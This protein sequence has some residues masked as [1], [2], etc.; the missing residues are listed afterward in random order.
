[1]TLDE[2]HPLEYRRR[3]RAEQQVERD[4]SAATNAVTARLAALDAALAAAAGRLPEKRLAPARELTCRATERLRLS[5]SHTVVALAGATGSGKSSLFNALAG[6]P[7]SAVG[8]RRP[9]TG[10]AHAVIWGAQGAGPLLDWLQIPRR[11]YLSFLG[12]PD[13]GDHRLD[14]LVLLDMPD[15]DS[16]TVPHRLE[17]D[18]L[19]GLV[20]VLVW[21]LDPQKYAD[22]AVHDR[23]LRPLAEHAGVVVVVL[24]QADLLP[25]HQVDLALD[26]VRRLLAADGLGTVPVLATS[27]ADASGLAELRA[28]LADAVTAHMAGLRRLA[29]DLDVVAAGLAGVVAGPARPDLD[30]AAI[31]ELTG[32]LASAAGVPAVRTAVHQGYLHRA[33]AVSGWPVLRWLRRLRPDPLRRLHPDGQTTTDAEPARSSVPTPSAVQRSGV[34]KALRA[35]AEHAAEGLPAPWPEAVRETARSG[36]EKLTDALDRAVTGTDLGVTGKPLWWRGFGALQA[37]CMVAAVVGAL[38]LAG[39]FTLNV[40]R[41]PEPTAPLL[42]PIPLPAVLLLGGLGLG[43]LLALPA[44]LLARLRAARTAAQAEA[45]LRATVAELADDLVVSPI[46]AELAAYESL[47]TALGRL[48]APR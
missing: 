41:L 39:L 22:A 38:W 33:A 6:A 47:R 36:T 2:M 44:R 21:V 48:R 15:H 19:V 14:G 16:T 46:R 28:V 17:V 4:R 26:D 18:R 31:T 34:D 29:A 13:D 11:H 23:Y 27:A 1:M 8:V 43:L 25:A 3:R 42:G 20:D 32:A 45:R 35:V 5:G 37:V 40:L 7:V 24:N 9:T 10:L 30:Q 12:Q